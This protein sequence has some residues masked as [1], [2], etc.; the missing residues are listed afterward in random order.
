[1]PILPERPEEPDRLDA[2]RAVLSR[3]QRVVAGAAPFRLFILLSVAVVASSM[4]PV[5]WGQ[6]AL[7]SLLG[8]ALDV[9]RR[10]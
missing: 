4:A 2:A 5:P 3:A 1:M 9:A 7:L 10:R 8:I 6:L